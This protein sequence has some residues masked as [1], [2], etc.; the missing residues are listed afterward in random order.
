MGKLAGGPG[1]PWWPH[2]PRQSGQVSPLLSPTAPLQ[3]AA[4]LWWGPGALS[5]QCQGSWWCPCGTAVSQRRGWILP[6]SLRWECNPRECRI[7]PCGGD[8]YTIPVGAGSGPAVLMVIPPRW[9]QDLALW[10]WQA[11]GSQQVD[12]EH[13]RTQE[14]EVTLGS[15]S[16][17]RGIRIWGGFGATAMHGSGRFHAGFCSTSYCGC[18]C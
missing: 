3:L 16:P 18:P 12:G 1:P 4:V 15:V 7:R 13:G 9:V 17:G 6:L 8:G 11:A 14:P 5:R 2:V 10:W